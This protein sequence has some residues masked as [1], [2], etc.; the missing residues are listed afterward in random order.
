MSKKN[1]YVFGIHAVEQLL[2]KS[3]ET[4]VRA[5][6][7]KDAHSEALQQLQAQLASQQVACEQAT[8]Q[9][10][11][12]WVAGNHQGI[13][14]EVKRDKT[15]QAS[16]SDVLAASEG[17]APLFLVLD[18]VQDP[19]NLGACIR[20]AVAAGV[21][22]VIIPKDRA[23]HVNETVRK[24]ASGGVE[25]M[26]IITVTNLA[27]AL[28]EL[29]QAGVW[30]VGTSGNAQQTIYDVDMTVAI[31]IVMGG[32]EKG[33]RQL[34]EKECDYLASIPLLGEIE[35]LN[36]SVAAGVSLYEVIRQRRAA[37]H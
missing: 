17:R 33:L 32:E 5:W 9:K 21:T 20:T 36:V 35:S 19:H 1:D 13:V 29:K 23:A 31:A 8:K 24:V 25:E 10:L 37:N 28:Q 2:K 18:S 22:A 27:R 34:T 16:L 4:I 14:V 15:E 11:H 6:L 26:T 7:Q 12:K 30:L 3:P